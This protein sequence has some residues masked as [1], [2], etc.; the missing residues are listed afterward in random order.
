MKLKLIIILAWALLIF[1][2]LVSAWTEKSIEGEWTS[3][4]RTY[5]KMEDL[6]RETS[7]KAIWE[8]TIYNFSGYYATVNLTELYTRR[9]EWWWESSGNEFDIYWNFTSLSSGNKVLLTVGFWEYQRVWG[10]E[11]GR[12]VMGATGFNVG[13]DRLT[14]YAKYSYDLFPAF[15]EIWVYRNV[16][17]G[18]LY[19]KLL[20]YDPDVPDPYDLAVDDYFEIDPADFKDVKLTMWVEHQGI[21]A[22]EGGMS[23]K[24]YI[25]EEAWTPEIPEGKIKWVTSNWF[26]DFIDGT[27]RFFS[28]TLPGYVMDFI[29]VATS[30]A[31]YFFELLALI[32]YSAVQ[33]LPIFPFIFLFWLLDA[34][35]TS[36]VEGELQPIGNAVMTIYNTLRGL[37]QAIVSFGHA[38]WN[39]IKFW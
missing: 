8:T 6:D 24:I 10:L 37:A 38:I 28:K 18:K 21:G 26:W 32:G 14:T 39:L 19:T 29:N 11:W 27:K 5:W 15:V 23:D 1:I 25:E 2:P 34:I 17:E 30:W 7:G 16:S 33:F 31:G 3:I 20:L 36:I 4:S 13:L 35:I 12:Y 9:L 22:I